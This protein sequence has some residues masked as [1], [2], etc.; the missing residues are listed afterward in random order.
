MA[1]L[2]EK[3]SKHNY[4]SFLWHA[5]FLALASSFMDVDTVMPSVIADAGGSAFHIGLLLTIML[6]GCSISQ[7]VFASYLHSKRF[8]KKF[9]LAGINLRILALV[10]LALLLFYAS[11][12]GGVSLIWSILILVSLFS[13]SGAFANISYV[14]LLGKLV[15]RDHRKSLLSLKQVVYSTGILTSAIAAYRILSMY[16]IPKSYVVLFILASVFLFTASLGF[17]QLR[18]VEGMGTP[19]RSFRS[20]L[21]FIR[22]EIRRNRKLRNYLL[23]ISTLG[24]ILSLMAFLVLYAREN[25]SAYNPQVGSM[26]V[27]KI[28]GSVTTGAL[29][30]YFSR[31]FRYGKLLYLTVFLGLAIPLIVLLSNVYYLFMLTFFMGG[32]L[33]AIYSVSN[34]GILLEI[35]NI[36]TRA[37]YAGAAG[38]GSIVPASFSLLGGWLIHTFGF[39]MFFILFIGIIMSSLIF[40]KR[41]HCRK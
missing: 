34:S 19:G 11:N 5:G 39:E 24:N 23:I 32:I 17:W 22:R 35:S 6:G 20:F 37:T 13:F 25:F 29:L 41:L 26:L 40:I 27:L 14:D 33:T 30:F 2:T 12:M 1:G 21:R 8:K 31:R 18:E 10:G 7:L 3:M 9:L 38:L 4:R 15:K 36:R 16:Q 28:T